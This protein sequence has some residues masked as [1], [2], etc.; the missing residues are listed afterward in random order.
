MN[1]K[2]IE[3]STGKL[4]T[5]IRQYITGLLVEPIFVK[6]ALQC[7]FTDILLD[8][9]TQEAKNHLKLGWEERTKFDKFL[10]DIT[11]KKDIAVKIFR[12]C[13]DSFIAKIGV[14]GDKNNN[15]TWPIGCCDTLLSN[16]EEYAKEYADFLGVKYLGVEEGVKE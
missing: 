14:L 11:G 2:Q 9:D 12:Q 7:L 5:L 4:V 1:K 8:K 15:I 6:N 13:D 16:V 10:L 3:E